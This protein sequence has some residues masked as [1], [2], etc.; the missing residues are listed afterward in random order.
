ML[1]DIQLMI[2]CVLDLMHVQIT[3]MG[4]TFSFYSMFLTLCVIGIITT[5]VCIIFKLGGD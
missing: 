3:L 1:A 5:F 4:F 2:N